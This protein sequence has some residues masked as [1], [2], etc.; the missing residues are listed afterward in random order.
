VGISFFIFTVAEGFTDFVPGMSGVP[1]DVIRDSVKKIL[2]IENFFPTYVH[3]QIRHLL[4]SRS[5]TTELCVL[6]RLIRDFKEGV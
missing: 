5:F 4:G 1:C 6:Y 3:Q 2:M